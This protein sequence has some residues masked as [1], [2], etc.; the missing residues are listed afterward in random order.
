MAVSYQLSTTGRRLLRLCRNRRP[1]TE[2]APLRH[3]LEQ[4]CQLRLQRAAF[5][6]EID[7]AVREQ[8]LGG[9]EPFGK[10]VANRL[11]DYPRTGETDQRA[12]LGDVEVTEHRQ[13]G[14]HAS[15]GR[16][17]EDGDVRHAL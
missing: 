17:G 12:R 9:L 3:P 11:L 5:D 4:L 15:G 2:S 8:E 14:C 16:I 7:H 13:R 6:Y 1:M 10:G